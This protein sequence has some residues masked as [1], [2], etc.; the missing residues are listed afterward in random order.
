MQKLESIQI[1]F[2]NSV[3]YKDNSDNSFIKSTYPDE[4]LSIYRHTIFENMR[5]A[6]KITFPGVWILL[7]DACAE[8]VAYAF[9]KTNLPSSGCLDD[10]GEDFPIFISKIEELSILPYIKDY[11]EFEWLKNKAYIV[12]Q[13]KSINPSALSKIKPELIEQIKFKFIESTI[14]YKSNFSIDKI[15]EIILSDQSEKISL[16]HKEVYTIIARLQK[17]VTIF[18]IEEDLYYFIE[19]AMKGLSLSKTMENIEKKYPS[20]DLSMAIHFLLKKQLI[21]EITI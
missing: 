2:Q 14:L 5:N 11:A 10:F 15:E 8:S 16:A 20:F 12:K 9:C 4:R 13:S 21:T 7:G 6:L 3:L 17:E 19:F 18:W 1:N